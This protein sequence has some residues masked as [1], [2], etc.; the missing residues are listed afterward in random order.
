MKTA[1]LS[2]SIEYKYCT[3]SRTAVDSVGFLCHLACSTKY[4]GWRNCQIKNSQMGT[5]LDVTDK[6]VTDIRDVTAQV[7]RY[8]H[9]YLR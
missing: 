5:N 9:L 1:E 4:G 2:K 6:T 3:E 8:T 7:G